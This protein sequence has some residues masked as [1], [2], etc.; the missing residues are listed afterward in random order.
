MKFEIKR[1]IDNLGR[2]ILPI[3]LRIYYGITQGDTLVIL[4]VRNGILLSKS[5]YFIMDELTD[6]M[7]T[8]IDV[9]G[10]FV[11]P[12]VFRNQYQLKPNDILKIV[13]HETCL[14]ISKEN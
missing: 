11:V 7:I 3:D 9:L 14:L 4:P 13:P 10:R 5:N 8:T 1:K 6:A 12:A 2:I